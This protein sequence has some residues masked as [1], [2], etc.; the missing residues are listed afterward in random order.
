MEQSSIRTTSSV[1]GGLTLTAP[2]PKVCT[3]LITSLPPS[4]RPP[5]PPAP[6][7]V[8]LLQTQTV[9]QLEDMMLQLELLRMPRLLMVRPLAMPEMEED[10]QFHSILQDREGDREEE[11]KVNL[12][13]PRLFDGSF[14]EELVILFFLSMAVDKTKCN[15]LL[16]TNHTNTGFGFRFKI[17]QNSI[18]P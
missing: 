10:H 3:A 7:E 4:V 15:G 5:P 11:D 9:L 14:V 2:R 17:F 13:K 1:T 8:T 6:R 18:L 16:S 12:V